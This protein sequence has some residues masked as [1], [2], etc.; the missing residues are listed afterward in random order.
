[1]ASEQTI[2]AIWKLHQ[3]GTHFPQDW[4]GK[5]SLRDAYEVQQGILKRKLAAGAKQSGWK[6]GFTAD[7]VR[8]MFGA[9]AP[10]F[11]YLLDGNMKPSGHEFSLKALGS[12]LVESEVLVILGKDLKGPGVTTAQAREAVKEIA[13]AFE[14]ITRRGDPKVDVSLAVADNVMQTAYV[15]GLPRPLKDGEN[16][17]DIRVEALVNGQVGE[18]VLGK[19]AMDNPIDSL[20]WLANSLA[21][22]GQSLKA[23]QV[24]LTGTFT[25]PPVAKS[26]DK[27][28][29]RFSGL[30][31]V[32]ASFA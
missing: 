28:E 4:I 6:I 23:G 26:G 19:E 2:D 20:A 24:V 18:T 13:P 11:G 29:S 25:K 5:L 1:M 14:I 7:A 3:A 8:K 22:L 27:F 9:S 10:V 21:P 30:G 12:A 31:T 17:G 32:K 15:V 16:L